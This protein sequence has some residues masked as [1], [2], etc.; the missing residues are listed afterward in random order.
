[1]IGD[2]EHKTDMETW[3]AIGIHIHKLV[4]RNSSSITLTI[5]DDGNNNNVKG[6]NKLIVFIITSV[7]GNFSNNFLLQLI[8]VSIILQTKSIVDGFKVVTCGFSKRTIW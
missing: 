1:M 6:S 7:W 2:V 8:R 4:F 3:I 5:N